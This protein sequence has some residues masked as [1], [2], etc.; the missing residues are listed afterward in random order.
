V[1]IRPP[2]RS[3]EEKLAKL[4]PEQDAELRRIEADAIDRFEGVVDEL[5]SALGLLRIGHHVGWKVL[6]LVH[7]KKTIRKYEDILGVKIRD[8]FPE[9]G[10]SSYR[11]LGLRVAEKLSN[12]WKA[13]SGEEKVEGRRELQR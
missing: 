8:V 6:Y 13:V 9:T 5:E 4:T 7:S 12:F 2:K 11:S 10:P 1:P 3:R